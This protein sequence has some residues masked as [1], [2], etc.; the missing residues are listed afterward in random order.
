M[1]YR[2]LKRVWSHNHMNHIPRFREI[3]PELKNV[4]DEEM[5]NRWISLGI[6]FY[7]QEKTE[8]KWY[9][10]LTLPFAIALLLLMF[11]SLPVNFLITGYW[12]YSFSKN[13]RI[14]N[15]LTALKLFR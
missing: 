15:W 4:S 12:G 3:F 8:V 9:L 5:C 10:R 1:I 11:V 14:Y 7:T 13:N 6:N 2:K